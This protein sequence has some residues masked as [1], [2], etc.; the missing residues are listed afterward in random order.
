MVVKYIESVLMI[1]VL[2]VLVSCTLDGFKISINDATYV[3]FL[4]VKI[5]SPFLLLNIVLSK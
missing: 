4:M 5:I 1:K 2:G 3:N